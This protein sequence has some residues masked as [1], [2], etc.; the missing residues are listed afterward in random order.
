ML[1]H[2]DWPC[3]ALTSLPD[4]PSVPLHPPAAAASKMKAR[5]DGGHASP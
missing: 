5:A 2:G 4:P 1:R 3:L